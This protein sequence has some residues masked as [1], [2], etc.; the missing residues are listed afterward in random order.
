M[1]NTSISTNIFSEFIIQIVFNIVQNSMIELDSS[2]KFIP[3]IFIVFM[4]TC[5]LFFEILNKV[6]IIIYHINSTNAHKYSC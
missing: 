5:H 4:L 3:F 1:K 6:M 2:E